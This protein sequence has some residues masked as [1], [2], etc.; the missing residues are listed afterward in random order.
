VRLAAILD[1]ERTDGLRESPDGL[2]IGCGPVQVDRNDGSRPFGQCGLDGIRG[3]RE[4]IPRNI[5]EHRHGSDTQNGRD[6]R[7]GRV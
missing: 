6:C 1:D 2:E 7:A 3:H 5:N 4:R